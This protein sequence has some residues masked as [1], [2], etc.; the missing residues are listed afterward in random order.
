MPRKRK[1]PTIASEEN[2]PKLLE[3]LDLIVTAVERHEVIHDVYTQTASDLYRS[4]KERITKQDFQ[5]DTADRRLD[6]GL[7]VKILVDL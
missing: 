4:K 3:V 6:L 1:E 7:D 5:G 2:L